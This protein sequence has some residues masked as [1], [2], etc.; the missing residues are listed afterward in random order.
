MS[1]YFKINEFECPCCKKNLISSSLIKK[2]DEARELAGVPFIINSGYRCE[3]HNKEVGSSKTSSHLL[4]LA[5][6]IR[7]LHSTTRFIVIGALIKAGFTRL[8]IAKDFIHVDI[9]NAKANGVIWT[10]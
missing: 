3:K 8:G 6:D 10:Y 7:V 4:G 5:V 2:L 1:K 9:D